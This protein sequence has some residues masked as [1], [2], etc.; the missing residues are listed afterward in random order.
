ML[1]K[2]YVS[3]SQ[4]V[5]SFDYTDIASGTG[6]VIYYGG[7]L[8]DGS[9]SGSYILTDNV[10]Y[11]HDITTETTL[12]TTSWAKAVE[13][14]FDITFNLPRIIK[15]IAIL[16]AT[17][18]TS[19]TGA[20]TSSMTLSGAQVIKV[21]NGTEE[22][23]CTFADSSFSKT[24]A[25][26]SSKIQSFSETITQNNFKQGD[27]LRLRLPLW[28][29]VNPGAGVVWSFAHDPKDRDDPNA[30]IHNDD[31]TTL[32]LHIPFKIDI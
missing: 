21:S 11:S 29:K 13:E 6:Y 24:G 15:G 19:Y 4:A 27:V 1:Q 12:N 30:Y 10:F 31:T 32:Q 23:L 2:K 17:I 28:V 7:H 22:V 9:T 14:D 5:A 8:I 18:G 16:N 26:K 25:Q 20:G 3:Q